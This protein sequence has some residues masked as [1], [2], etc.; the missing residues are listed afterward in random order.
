MLRII[1]NESIE[2]RALEM[3]DNTDIWSAINNNRLF[4]RKWLPFINYMHSSND[5]KRF[6]NLLLQN[7]RSNGD[8]IFVIHYNHQFAG[9]IGFKETDSY[10]QKSEI[11]YWLTEEMQ[12]KGIILQATKKL[13][14]FAFRNMELNR[15]QI[16]C[17]TKNYKSKAIPEKLG[18]KFEGTEREAEKLGSKFHDLD[19]Y[20]YLKKEW[21]E[22]LI[23]K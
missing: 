13:T 15:I 6:I 2:L 11:G 9:M 8:E 18:F 10:N 19:V 5:V 12:G 21:K 23:A 3:A 22:Q 14:E 20:S 4:L 1:I 7:K 17:A 16:K